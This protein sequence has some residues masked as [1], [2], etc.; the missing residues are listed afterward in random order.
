MLTKL[1]NFGAFYPDF[2]DGKT[3]NQGRLKRVLLYILAWN[4]VHACICVLHLRK[5]YH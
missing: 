5:C 3:S 4:R 2:L 1:E